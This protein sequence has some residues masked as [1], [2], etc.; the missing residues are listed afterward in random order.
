VN[1]TCRWFTYRPST[2]SAP[3]CLGTVPGSSRVL[4]GP[5]SRATKLIRSLYPLVKISDRDPPSSTSRSR[6]ETAKRQRNGSPRSAHCSTVHNLARPTI[7]S[8]RL[9]HWLPHP[10][11]HK[12][13]KHQVLERRSRCEYSTCTWYTCAADD[14]RPASA[15]SPARPASST[16]PESRA[17]KLIGSLLPHL[18]MCHRDPAQHHVEKSVGNVEM[19][20]QLRLPV[21]LSYRLAAAFQT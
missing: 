3:A 21:P 1:N 5:E 18:D 15:P 7:T 6:S 14:E 2:T 13:A 4:L 10:W 19:L 17:T 20:A 16:A 8:A 12:R 11:V 9:C